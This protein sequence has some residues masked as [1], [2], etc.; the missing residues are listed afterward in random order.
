MV[1]V[2]VRGVMCYPTDEELETIKNWDTTKTGVKP[3]VDYVTQRWHHGSDWYR[4]YK[5]KDHLFRKREVIKVQL[6]TAGWSGNE[7]IMAALG[8]NIMFQYGWWKSE[9]G[10]HY[11][12]EFRKDMWEKK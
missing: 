5:A 2:S 7:S 4:V 8:Q 10:G 1:L 12:Y 6:H 3:L 9:S 11:W